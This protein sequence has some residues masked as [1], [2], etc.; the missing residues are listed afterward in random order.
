[1]KPR[2]VSLA[3]GVPWLEGVTLPDPPDLAWYESLLADTPERIRSV[4][5]KLATNAGT[6][7]AAAFRLVDSS[8]F[9]NL[10][11]RSGLPPDSQ[12]A[13]RVA[14]RA[15]IAALRPDFFRSAPPGG[16][17]R[18]GASFPPG[19]LLSASSEGRRDPLVDDLRATLEVPE[20]P[21]NEVFAC[22]DALTGLAFDV[23]RDLRPV[24]A[25]LLHNPPTTGSAWE[26]PLVDWFDLFWQSQSVLRRHLPSEWS[27][28]PT[29]AVAVEHPMSADVLGVLSV[30]PLVA[31]HPSGPRVQWLV[32][33]SREVA[34]LAAESLVLTVSGVRVLARVRWRDLLLIDG[35][36]ATSAT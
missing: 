6:E 30:L 7:G 9:K 26:E 28:R 27:A 5:V 21:P 22:L 34:R 25:H 10:I 12:V 29:M 24:V 16:S 33:D 19:S 32:A 3:V 8:L 4:L 2:N 18:P 36:L 20:S 17:K 31:T 35:P 15:G 13:E 1:M 14:V 23:A 11:S